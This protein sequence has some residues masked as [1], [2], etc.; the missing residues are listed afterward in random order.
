MN[1]IRFTEYD[2]QE[3][4]N[5]ET[6]CFGKDANSIFIHQIIEDTEMD[7][8][9]PDAVNMTNETTNTYAAESGF[10]ISFTLPQKIIVDGNEHVICQQLMT[11]PNGYQAVQQNLYFYDPEDSVFRIVQF[12]TA[13]LAPEIWDKQGEALETYTD[14]VIHQILSNMAL[15]EGV[16]RPSISKFVPEP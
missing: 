12:G 10:D 4:P 9:L 3:R 13:P 6:I 7:A 11:L 5:D 1:Y 14:K 16:F 8:P 15:P 2:Y